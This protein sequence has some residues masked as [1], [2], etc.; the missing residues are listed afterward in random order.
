[1]H[2]VE[3]LNNVSINVF[4]LKFCQDKNKWKHNLSPIEISKNESDKNFDFL[5]YENG[6]IEKIHV[7]LGYHNK[8]FL[9]RRCL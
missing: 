5:I 7:F 1:M 4:E 8:S 9:C 6:L 2:R 3:K